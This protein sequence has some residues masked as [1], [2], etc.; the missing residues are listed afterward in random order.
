MTFYEKLVRNWECG[1]MSVVKNKEGNY[2]IFSTKCG[3]GFKRS[4][5]EDSIDKCLEYIGVA[6]ANKYEIEE[7]SKD[8]KIVKTIDFSEL[9]GEGYKK[10]DKVRTLSDAREKR[11][12]SNLSCNSVTEQIIQDGYGYINRK[13]GTD[14]FVWNKDRDKE[15][16][17]PSSAIEPWL[18]DEPKNPKRIKIDDAIYVL[19]EE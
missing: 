10:G 3:D 6:Y 16:L 13:S 12:K 7:H 11:A 4:V 18:E 15:V 8:W 17:F 19:E 14:W 2:M 5:W 1:K 9:G